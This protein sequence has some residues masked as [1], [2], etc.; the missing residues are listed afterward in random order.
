MYGGKGQ[1]EKFDQE[2][3]EIRLNLFLQ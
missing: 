3:E 2:L 1:D